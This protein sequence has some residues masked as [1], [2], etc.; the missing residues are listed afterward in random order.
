M[1]YLHRRPNCRS[2][3][4]YCRLINIMPLTVG[5]QSIY[6]TVM[7][8]FGFCRSR[9]WS[10]GKSHKIM[11]SCILLTR[12]LPVVLWLVLGP[13]FA[14]QP[15]IQAIFWFTLEQMKLLQIFSYYYIPQIDRLVAYQRIYVVG[16]A[17]D[18]FYWLT[19]NNSEDIIS[20]QVSWS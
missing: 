8:L 17:D 3:G 16:D 9:R 4:I 6:P 1:P 13:Q 20:H 14:T 11:C 15:S 18:S 12:R 10:A 19:A 5:G 2:L 7:R